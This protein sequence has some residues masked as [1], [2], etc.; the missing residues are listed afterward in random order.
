MGWESWAGNGEAFG[1]GGTKGTWLITT[2]N[3][4]NEDSKQ[5]FEVDFVI[6]CIGRFSRVLNVPKFPAKNGPEVFEGKVLHSMDYSSM[7]NADAAEQIGGK[8]VVVVGSGF[9]SRVEEG[10]IVLKKSKTI[11]FS[12]Q[13]GVLLD[14]EDEPTIEADVVIFATGFSGDQKLRDIFVSPWLQKIVVGPSNRTVPLYRECIHPRI[15]Q[16]A[17]IGY[18]ESLTNIY[19]AETMSRWVSHFL[20]G[21]FRLPSVRC[22]EKDVAEWEKYKKR[23]NMK[24]FRRSCV[25]R[26]NIWYNDL[27]CRDMGCDRK[28]KKGWFAEWFEPYGPADYAGLH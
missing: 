11:R 2:Q 26:V 12:D 6:L 24:Y 4:K 16:L 28:R 21:R 13:R 10:S 25:S 18:S 5:I 1:C 27:L 23:Y 17:I 15:P 3:T 22:M 8:R 20:G 19:A 7:S 14:G 9:Y